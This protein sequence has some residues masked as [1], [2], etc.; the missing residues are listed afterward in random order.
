MEPRARS[1][2]MLDMVKFAPGKVGVVLSATIAAK[3]A[4]GGL[5]R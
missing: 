4:W 1:K 5:E 3:H 2:S